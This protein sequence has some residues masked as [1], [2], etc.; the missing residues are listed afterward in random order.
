MTE[1]MVQLVQWLSVEYPFGRKVLVRWRSRLGTA[2]D[3]Y[4][5]T[6]R[7]GKRIEIYLSRYKCRRYSDAIDTIIHEWVHAMHWPM[8][9]AEYIPEH[10]HHPPAFWAQYGEIID[11]WSHQGGADEAN[12]YPY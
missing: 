2:G 11:R 12:E 6:Y 3:E 5:I 10:R 4:G 9:N 7:V 1:R 8:A